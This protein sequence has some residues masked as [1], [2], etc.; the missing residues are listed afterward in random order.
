MENVEQNLLQASPV[1]LKACYYAYRQCR[2]RKRGKPGV[3]AYEARLLDNLFT[4]REALQTRRWSPSRSYSFVV[5]RPKA[6]EIHVALFRDRVVHH[7][8]TPRLEALFEPVFIHDSYSNRKGKGAHKAVARV[9][10]FMRRLQ[11]A[12]SGLTEQ[13][14]VTR[15]SGHAWYLQL[16]IKNFFNRIN[17]H[18][19][20]GILKKRIAKAERQGKVESEQAELLRYLCYEL[21]RKHPSANTVPIHGAISVE[22]VP[23][24]KRLINAPPQCGLP[25]GNL[26]SQFF[27]NVYL[28][29]LD[30]FVK[31]TLKC[32]CYVRYVDDFVLLHSDREQLQQWRRQIE[33]FL[34]ERLQLELK[35]SG[36]LQSMHNGLDFLGYIIR[37]NYL[38]VR[39]RVVNHCREKLRAFEKKLLLTHISFDGALPQ[40][41]SISSS[42]SGVEGSGLR[43]PRSEVPASRTFDSAKGASERLIRL[44]PKLLFGNPDDVQKLRAVLSSYLGHFSHAAHE[45][46]CQQLWRE[47]PWLDWLFIRSASSSRLIPRW[48]P[49]SVSS[50]RSQWQYFRKEYPGLLL[51]QT[52]WKVSAFGADAEVLQ[53][54]CLQDGKLVDTQPY[55]P[56]KQWFAPMNKLETILNQLQQRHR[57]YC[58]VAEQGYL[59]GG[60]KR[61]WMRELAIYG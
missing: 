9:Q 12:G 22:A 8:L 7:L 56:G 14:T 37:P 47:F 53:R 20:F 42:L 57:P 16:D 23:A 45:R 1:S 3:L 60:M 44:V 26:T 27:A 28:N 39:R 33:D 35:N 13:S 30:Q 32:Q 50:F 19:L 40:C 18:I 43:A 10:H 61:R 6:R 17:R 49:Q 5:T 36:Q 38:L 15:A 41:R 59:R 4:L 24:H 29:E 31:H 11:N 48:E 25:I 51:M 46:Q 58:Y 2:R 21:L 55:M 54:L 34:D 52:G